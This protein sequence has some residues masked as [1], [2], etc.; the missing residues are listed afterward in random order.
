MRKNPGQTLAVSSGAAVVRDGLWVPARRGMTV[1]LVLLVTLV[2]FEAL[3]V[4]TALP[5]ASRELGGLGL[6]GWV[7]SAFMLSTVASIAMSGRAI[8]QRGLYPVLAVG[9][10][11]FCIGLAIGATAPSMAVL[12]GGRIVQGLG[13]GAISSVAN[14]AIGRAYPPQLRAAML[15]VMSS[16]WVVPG[17]IGPGL[18]ALITTHF[19]WRWVFAGL[20]PIVAVAAVLTLPA[21]RPFGPLRVAHD[22]LDPRRT[23]DPLLVA[24]GFAFVIGG[25][26]NA[27]DLW[28]LLLAVIGFGLAG[29]ALARLSPLGTFRLHR[30]PSAA[31]ALNGM[32]SCAF[33]AADAF[34]PLGV[35][36]VR[37][38]SVGF[39][40]L[41]LTTGALSWTA[42]AWITARL[43]TRVAV[44]TRVRAGF[45]CVGAG[46]AIV[47]LGLRSDVPIAIFPI[48]WL[49][50]GLGMGLGYQG[51]A[52]VVLGG[53][54]DPD[55]TGPPAKTVAARQMFD[56]LGNA[57]GTGVAG[58]CVAVA[59]AGHHHTRTGL[60]I[61]FLAMI[62]VT[63]L[64]AATAGRAAAITS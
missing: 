16:S 20:V 9:A 40:G 44:G 4:N 22:A 21:L 50:A 56:T 33:F 57:V 63:I 7:F 45:V 3:A 48:A 6:Y 54:A 1:G 59:A 13:A 41:A 60:T 46:I 32:I 53:D 14:V 2:A 24:V 15:A 25:L 11:L 39:A 17:L 5:A 29:P 62:G 61:A 19:G 35:T 26:S 36:A 31:I 38:R 47:V 49:V 51:L 8:D 43:N 27:Q 42:G 58:A 10:P 30:G 28:P 18:S 23:A 55:D 12:V 34:I 64:G 37:H 52:L